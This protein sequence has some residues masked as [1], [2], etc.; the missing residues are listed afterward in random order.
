MQTVSQ[1]LMVTY[2]HVGILPLGRRARFRDIF[3]YKGFTCS[4]QKPKGYRSWFW[5]ELAVL[6]SVF[7]RVASTQ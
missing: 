7:H 1:G 6:S 2:D 5:E 3:S 4:L